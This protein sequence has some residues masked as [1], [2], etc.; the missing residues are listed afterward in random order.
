MYLPALLLL[1][2]FSLL[3][4]S[5]ISPK[6]HPFSQLSLDHGRRRG[7]AGHVWSQWNKAT[8]KSQTSLSTALHGWLS[9]YFCIC[10][11]AKSNGIYTCNYHS[12]F[13]ELANRNVGISGLRGLGLNKQFFAYMLA[14]IFCLCLPSLPPSLH[15]EIC[16]SLDYSNRPESWQ[17]HCWQDPPSKDVYSVLYWVIKNSNQT[18]VLKLLWRIHVFSVLFYILSWHTRVKGLQGSENML[19]AT[20]ETG[21]LYYVC[22][23]GEY[24]YCMYIQ[25]GESY[26]IIFPL[27]CL[28]RTSNQTRRRKRFLSCFP[29]TDEC[30]TCRSIQTDAVLPLWWVPH[31]PIHVQ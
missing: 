12:A 3:Y 1:D 25:S 6:C 23:Y 21:Q 20:V 27:S 5:F 4:L 29:S 15:A 10:S 30:L 9:D 19:Q 26:I 22:M 2:T 16:A 8:G 18:V 14:F 17:H 7:A 13:R 28:S 31:S 11:R 24:F